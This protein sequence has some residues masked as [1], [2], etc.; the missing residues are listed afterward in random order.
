IRKSRVAIVTEGY[1]DTIACHQAGVRNAVATLGTAMTAGNARVLRRLCDTVVLLFDGDVAG[2]KAA[3][4]AVEVFFAEPVDVRIATLSPTT[5]AKD[6]DEL[7]KRPG[8]ADTL[9]EVIR[10]AIDP[11][12]LI[13]AR[14]RSSLDGQ[15]LSARSRLVKEFVA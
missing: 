14:V 7:L 6:P 5:D 4:R 3:E 11:L 8:G 2:Q 9:R 12:D 10:T 1:M 15:G 13:F